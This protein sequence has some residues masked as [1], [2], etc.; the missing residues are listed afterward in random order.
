MR[1]IQAFYASAQKNLKKIALITENNQ[2]SYEEILFLVRSCETECM[3]RGLRQGHRVVLATDRPEFLLAFTLLASRRSLTLIF[4]TAQQV[5]AAGVEFEFMI[6][7][8]PSDLVEPERQIIIEPEWFAALG[9][10]MFGDFGVIYGEGAQLVHPSSGTTGIAKFISSSEFRTA[11]VATLPDQRI[12]GEPLAEMRLLA[13]I[14]MQMSWAMRTA[15]RV[16]MAGGSVVALGDHR[17]RPLQYIDL[18]RVTYFMTTPVVVRQMLELGTAR[19]YL[20]SLKAIRISGAYTSAELL[21]R[22]AETYSGRII[23]G[24]GASEIGAI[25]SAQYDPNK[26]RGDGYLGEI[27]RSDLEIAFFDENMRLLEGANEGIIGLRERGNLGGQKYIGAY[28]GDAKTGFMEGYFFPGDIMR[29][30]GE[31]LFMVGRI[32]NIINVGGN[33]IALE[34]VQS[35]LETT[36]EVRALAC[37]AHVDDLGL[38]TLAVCYAGDGELASVSVQAVLDVAFPSLRLGHLARLSELPTTS[39][40]K[41][42][43]EALRVSVVRET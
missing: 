40:G 9:A 28:Q 42:D 20:S 8:G 37:F 11:R 13:S 43:V 5:I 31:S 4:S 17:N 22:L 41:V 26:K 34:A 29:R 3:I 39:S 35:A 7:T 14:S 15:L 25:C 32:K 23:V 36:L 19:Q 33:K 18:Y 10:G 24:Y 12:D 16:L 21:A 30:E 38:E 27:S 6:S 2:L 1:L